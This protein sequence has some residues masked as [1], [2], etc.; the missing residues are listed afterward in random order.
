MELQQRGP[1]EGEVKSEGDEEANAPLLE[2]EN[3]ARH[4]DVVRYVD[5]SLDQV[6]EL[7]R[8]LEEGDAV[9][10]A[11]G[12]LLKIRDA[13]TDAL[14]APGAAQHTQPRRRSTSSLREIIMQ[15]GLFPSPKSYDPSCGNHP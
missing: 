6:A 15:G 8:L 9:H 14:E 7:V 1:L 12:Q 11:R 13:I 5:Q 10:L 2:E 4:L 3:A